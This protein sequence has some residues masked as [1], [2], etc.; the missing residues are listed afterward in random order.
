MTVLLG[1][2]GLV[3]ADDKPERN[4]LRVLTYNIHHGEGTDG[5][6]DL[7]RIAEVIKA[8]KPDVVALQE[9]DRNTTRT[10]KVDQAAELAKLTGL[11]AEFGKAIDLQG[12]GYGLA[13]LSRFPLKGA[14]VHS[15]P[16]KERQEA[17]IVLQVTVEPGGPFPALT[18]LNTHLQHDD[19]PTR[20]KQIAKI[21]ELFGTAAGAFVLAGDLNAAPASAP[22]KALAKNWAFATEPGRKGL[23]TI[24]SDTPR[25]QI[26]YILFRPADRFR[27]AEANVIEE[28]V[29]SDHRPV[30]A[31]VEWTGR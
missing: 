15:L 20:E 16:G 9:V 12:G 21:D 26:D 18:F 24:P 2:A 23:L 19:G 25:Q 30:F 11:N 31:L 10:G 4:V 13:V 6:L 8:A 3:P 28:K 7:A 27:V 17:R 14:K 1:L 29:A 5:K 22:I